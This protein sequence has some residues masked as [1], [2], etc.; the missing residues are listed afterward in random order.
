M[1]R[2]KRQKKSFNIWKYICLTIFALIVGLYIYVAF[3]VSADSTSINQASREQA[4]EVAHIKVEATRENAE[5]FIDQYLAQMNQDENFH[6]DINLQ[7]DGLYVAGNVSYLG[8]TYPFEMQTTP[9]VL[10]NGNI[11][12]NIES[13]TV[14][15][16]ELPRELILTILSTCDTFPEFIAINAE[17]NYIGVNLTELTLDNGISFGAEV[18]D[19]PA[20]QLE[21]SVYL[22]KDGLQ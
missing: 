4:G 2:R 13:I 6:Y 7:E 21:L 9:A 14:S 8:M 18:I 11:Q 5:Y 22:P 15:N 12:L 20:D 10:D 19:L 3:F 1:S 16:F 17:A